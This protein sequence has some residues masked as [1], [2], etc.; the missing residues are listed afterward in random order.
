MVKFSVKISVISR[1]PFQMQVFSKAFSPSLADVTP[2]K[3]KQGRVAYQRMV[4]RDDSA[5][6]LSIRPNTDLNSEIL[7]SVILAVISLLAGLSRT[8]TFL[9]TVE[10][11]EAGLELGMLGMLRMYSKFFGRLVPI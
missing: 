1:V 11:D 9:V 5:T 2:F 8:S 10:L 4:K 3:S 7:D 6:F